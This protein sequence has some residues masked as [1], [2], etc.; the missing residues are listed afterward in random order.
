ML[1]MK[2]MIKLQNVEHGKVKAELISAQIKT[3]YGK[4]KIVVIHMYCQKH[5][6]GLKKNMKK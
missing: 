3:K 4:P 5:N 2:C 6:I 1:M